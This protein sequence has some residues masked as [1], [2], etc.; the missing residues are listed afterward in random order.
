MPFRILQNQSDANLRKVP[1][2]LEKPDG[3]G[4]T[5]LTGITITYRRPDGVGGDLTKSLTAVGS[6][7]F[8]MDLGS[9]DVNV[10]GSG[11][12][13]VTGASILPWV[14]PVLI[15]APEP[16]VSS[17]ASDVTAIKA[18]IEGT[19]EPA[20]VSIQ[21]DTDNLQTRLPAALVS[22]RM[23]SSVGAMAS[24]VVTSAA[25]ADGLLTAA[26]FAANAI[27]STVMADNTITSAKIAD[28][29]ITVAKVADGFITSAKLATSA[30]NAI[31]DSII[32][33]TIDGARTVKG[34]LTR[35]NAF[36]KGKAAGLKSGTATFFMEDGTTKAMEFSQD[37]GAGTRVAASTVNGD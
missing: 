30:I 14:D 25:L 3:S 11:W 27:T 36:T 31:R 15:D 34:I 35:L 18:D 26:K 6:G 22:G 17:I 1:I 23:D 13:S 21:A 33:A 19:V 9:G 20:L 5:D 29:A 16:A 37:T 12:V 24:A 4:Q 28:A 7:R 10:T 8:T 2:Y 32:G